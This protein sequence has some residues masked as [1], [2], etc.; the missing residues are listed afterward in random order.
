MSKELETI[1]KAASAINRNV[2]QDTLIALQKFTKLLN[3][4]PAQDE[5][6]PTADRKAWSMPISRVEM[7]LDTLFFGLWWTE[8]FTTKQVLNEFVGELELVVV[9]PVTGMQIRRVGAAAIQITQDQ[10]A[11]IAQ[12]MDTKK[13]NALDLAYPKLKA[14]CV[15]NAAQSLGKRFGRDINRKAET[16]AEY[17]PLFRADVPI[18]LPE[19]GV[20]RLLARLAESPT[21]NEA[22][23]LYETILGMGV[24]QDQI[25]LIM[26]KANEIVEKAV[27][28]DANVPPITLFGDEGGAQ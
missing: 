26:A 3:Q 12:F 8:N 1:E 27:P 13:K 24:A 23:N 18:R 7:L 25:E 22:D 9:H 16:V 20:E 5:L 15:K 17:S 14:E 21:K 4:A 10:G 11:T 19:N 28:V 2:D 6:V